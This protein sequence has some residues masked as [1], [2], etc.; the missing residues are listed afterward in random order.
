[1]VLWHDYNDVN[2]KLYSTLNEDAKLVSNE[3]GKWDVEFVDGDYVNV[4]GLKSLVNACI[5]AIMTR[6]NE[7]YD[8]PLYVGFGCRVHELIK[9]NKNAMTVYKIK[10]FITK[11]L[12]EMRRV[13]KVNYVH[14]SDS[15]EMN[16]RYDV[17]FNIDSIDNLT[18]EGEL[19]L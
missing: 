3:Y 13:K 7:L 10:Q 17:V 16:H 11:T 5:I 2:H 15:G 19:M 1:M 4:D 8:N 12:E 9:D 14:V 6:Y 18:V